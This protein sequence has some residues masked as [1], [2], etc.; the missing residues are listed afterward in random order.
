M[1]H[2]PERFSCRV[3]GILPRGGREVL[4]TRSVFL[5]REFVNF[6]GGGVELGE[7]PMA[8]LRRE[9]EE[10]TGIR[11]EPVR[12]LYASEG[13]HVSTQRPWQLIGIYW[14]VRQTGGVLRP[15]GNGED[16]RACFWTALDRIPL[17]E[18]YPAD[19]EF[20]RKLVSGPV[21][22]PE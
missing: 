13:L 2:R 22:W 21:A 16:V 20:V 12:A 10:E 14:L 11:V 4:M 8:A 3:Y 1:N 6:P 17:G 15:E 18:M 5:D 19:L 9:F 7:A